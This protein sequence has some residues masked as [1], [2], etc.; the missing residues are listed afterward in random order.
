MIP[1]IPF[2]FLPVTTSIWVSLVI[3]A[4]TLFVVGFYKARTT[5]GSPGKSGVEMAVIGVV[6]ALVGYLVGLVLRVPAG[7]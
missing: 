2:F 4:L 3:A 5:V 7:P 1:L 6:S